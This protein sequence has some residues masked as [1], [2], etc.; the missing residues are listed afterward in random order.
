MMESRRS[1]NP[2]AYG[3]KEYRSYESEEIVFLK[4]KLIETHNKL[5]K[6]LE[7]SQKLE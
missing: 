6:E 5:L 2:F 3:T 1:N 4:E 7:N